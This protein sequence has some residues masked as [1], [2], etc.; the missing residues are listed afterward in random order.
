MDKYNNLIA[1]MTAAMIEAVAHREALRNQPA[2]EECLREYNAL[3]HWIDGTQES[4]ILLE[5]F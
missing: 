2:T 4:I 5:S 3:G 1:A